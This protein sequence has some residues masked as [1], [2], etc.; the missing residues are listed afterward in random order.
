MLISFSLQK[1]ALSALNRR[2]I[3]SALIHTVSSA[4]MVRDHGENQ[5]LTVQGLS[6]HGTRVTLCLGSAPQRSPSLPPLILPREP[7]CGNG[8]TVWG[9][10]PETLS[11]LVLQFPKTART[12]PLL[13]RFLFT[14]DGPFP[15]FTPISPMVPQNPSKSYAIYQELISI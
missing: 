6:F 2:V 10:E 15:C 14:P 9:G 5:P 7:K 11:R 4:R 1:A 8:E 12:S 3:T 13:E